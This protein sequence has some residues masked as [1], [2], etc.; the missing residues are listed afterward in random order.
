MWGK[1]ASSMSG[2]ISE[3]PGVAAAGPGDPGI[4]RVLSSIPVGGLTPFTT[5]DFPGR[6]AGV[7]YLQGCAWRCRY[8]YNSELWPFPPD[9]IRVPPEKILRFL[10]SRRGHLDGIVFSGGEPTAHADV[11]EWMRAVAASGFATGLHT[12]GMFPGRLKEVLPLCAWVGMDIK[13]PF[14]KYEKITGVPGS[15]EPCRRS[16][17][18]LIASGIPFECRT[19]VHP[20]L[21]SETEIVS[22]AGRIRQMGVTE[23]HLQIFRPDACP[24]KDLRG[25][26][27]ALADITAN[28]RTTL[29]QMFPIFTVRS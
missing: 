7:F 23:Y 5:I 25:S 19:T 9:G 11:G 2:N 13:A 22:L 16:L 21:L 4:R 6:L 15:G 17:E 8:C 1:K 27:G 18:I 28:L 29:S 12:N 26:P 20:D 24:D 3:N 14:E 10:E